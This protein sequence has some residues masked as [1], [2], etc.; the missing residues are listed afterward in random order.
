MAILDSELAAA[1]SLSKEDLENTESLQEGYTQADDRWE[2]IVR[3]NGDINAVA[4]QVGG[5][6]TEILTDQYAILYLTREQ[7]D[8]IIFYPEV[9]Y[10]EKPKGLLLEISR[11]LIASC[12]PQV[13]TL[14][15]YSL[16]GE[17]TLLAILDSGIDYLHPDFIREDGTSR[18]VYLWDQEITTG[19]PPPGFLEG[20]LY[21]QDEITAAIAAGSRQEAL[22]IVPSQD[23]VGHGTHV[24]G[25]AGGNGRASQGEYRG[26]APEAEFLIV[27]LD[28]SQGYGF[29][30]TTSLMRAIKFVVETAREM[31]RPVAI[32]ISLGTN[33][34]GH[35]GNSLFETYIDEWARRWNASIVVSAGNE[36]A[37][38]RHAAGVLSSHEEAAVEFQVGGNRRSV[39]L[40]LWKSYTDDLRIGLT[41]PDGERTGIIV[42]SPA[43]YQTVLQGTT[44]SV[45]YSL[46]NPYTIASTILIELFSPSQV[47]E[48]LWSIQIETGNVVGGQYDVWMTAT[49]DLRGNTFF[50]R[51]EEDVTITLPS[52]T[53]R[54][55]SVAAYNTETN[56]IASFSGRGFTRLSREIKPDI[57]APGVNITAPWPGGGYRAQ[58]GTSM[59]APFVTGSA[60]LLME[61]GIIRGNDVLLYGERLK[62]FLLKGASRD[63]RGLTYPDRDW[64]YGKLCLF[65]TFRDNSLVGQLARNTP[66]PYTGLGSDPLPIEQNINLWLRNFAYI[67]EQREAGVTCEEIVT[68]DQYLDLL[69]QGEINQD[70]DDLL[71]SIGDVCLQ[72]IGN[73]YL[74]LFLHQDEYTSAQ[75]IY[76]LFRLSRVPLLYGLCADTSALQ[77]SGITQLSQLTQE[78]LTGAGVVIAIIDT[79]ITYQHPAF[80]REDGSSKILAA[81]DQTNWQNNPPSGFLFGT[82]YTREDF[83]EALASDTPLEIVPM[84]DE[85]GHGTQIAGIAAGM[86]DYA[87][88]FSGAAPGADLIVVKLKPA[89]QNLRQFYQVPE[90]AIAYQHTDI[91]QGIEF[92]IDRAKGRPLIVLCGLGTNMGAHDGTMGL[93]QYLP[94]LTQREGVG[95]FVAAG[96][97][98][99]KSKHMS[100]MFPAGQ[101]G[102]VEEIEFFVAEGEAGLSLFIWN[103]VP[104]QMSI[105]ITSPRGYT[106]ERLPVMVGSLFDYPLPSERTR[107]FVR[108]YLQTEGSG[109]QCIS[110]KLQN[111]TPGLWRIN[112]YGD[113]ILNGRYD[114]WLPLSNWSQAETRFLRPDPYTTV[115][116]PSTDEGVITIGGYN[117]LSQSLYEA[118]GRGPTRGQR[119][120]PTIV[121]PAVGIYGPSGLEGYAPVTGT[122]AAAA[123][124]AGAGAQLMEWGI[125]LG[126]QRTMNTTIMKTY[127]IRGA[128]R[129]SGI[130]YPN[131][132]WG[133]GQLNVLRSLE[134]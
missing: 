57:S 26:V 87:Q 109:D 48:G 131:N 33:D 23:T 3:Y 54:T 122:S 28:S 60:A 118:T 63:M 32:N 77:A 13:Q 49:Q 34:G 41:A 127:L 11:G 105:S 103:Y 119:L 68:S 124:A 132:E 89:K 101:T 59:A 12:I 125:L 25:I 45:Y 86:P 66:S 36:G 65:A 116:V 129:K 15:D 96:N 55:I 115:T 104:D 92:A 117:H 5:A 10:L 64:G 71:K 69:F 1:L 38:A 19:T 134:Q 43:A 74:L 30:K 114:V 70:V 79:G 29:T 113:I 107:V 98:G 50:L 111:P 88:D 80:I 58:S 52:T 112:L 95:A 100:G 67:R 42:P 9:E 24:A 128:D 20:S 27:K 39:F 72:P 94:T 47:A 126:N 102:S 83:D 35:D 37:A 106:I 97:E 7:I 120:K 93:E 40:Q 14:P 108:Y 18:I 31:R 81:W 53:V 16:R 61:W 85:V 51:P 21:T 62:A 133:Y 6:P 73:D 110:V 8:A 123:I 2:I 75:A 121:A 44:I 4:E 22:T 91:I 17:G 130:V 99:N 46:P 76:S 90:D 84:R 82:E 78:P 56:S